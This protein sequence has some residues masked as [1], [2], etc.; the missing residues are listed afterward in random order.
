MPGSATHNPAC[1]IL[2]PVV[3]AGAATLGGDWQ[4]CIAA[5]IG[6]AS[7]VAVSPDLDMVNT[8]RVPVI[9]WIWGAYWWPYRKLIAHRA[10]ISHAPIAGTL[11]RLAYLMPIIIIAISIL[12][13][14]LVAAW[15]AGL[16]CADI[17]HAVLDALF[18][19]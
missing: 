17:G 18:T 11:V 16:A 5:G 13:P 3:M 9:G 2:A 14:G 1:L 8:V 15:A 19:N 7:G 4:T 6:C 12:P 10:Y